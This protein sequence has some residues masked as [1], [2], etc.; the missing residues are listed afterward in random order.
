LSVFLRFGVLAVVVGWCS[1]RVLGWPVAFDFFAPHIDIGL[2]AHMLVAGLG[3]YGFC[4]S[5]GR[6]SSAHQPQVSM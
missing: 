6:K 3:L 1:W 2:F 5:V 4:I